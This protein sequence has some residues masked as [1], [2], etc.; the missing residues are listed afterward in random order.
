[1]DDKKKRDPESEFYDG[2]KK[3]PVVLE[4]HDGVVYR[5]TLR[6]VSTYCLGVIVESESATREQL[7]MKGAI[8]TI[9]GAGA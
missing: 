1:M 7:F 9:W 3:K 2:I 5:G 8:K 4:T 6:W